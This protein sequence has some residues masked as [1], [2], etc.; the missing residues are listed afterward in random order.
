MGIGIAQQELLDQLNSLF[1]QK[2]GCP[3]HQT[4]SGD[5][6]TCSNRPVMKPKPHQGKQGQRWI[7]RA[8]KIKYLAELAFGGRQQFSPISLKAQN[9]AQCN[10]ISHLPALTAPSPRQEMTIGQQVTIHNDLS[11]GSLK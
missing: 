5:A 2:E 3:K 11:R 4:Q 1:M 9:S 6:P 7:D 10:R 8:L